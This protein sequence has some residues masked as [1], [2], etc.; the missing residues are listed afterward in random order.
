[1]ANGLNYNPA[2]MDS[3]FGIFDMWLRQF[4]A[5]NLAILQPVKITEIIDNGRLVNVQP[6]I[7]QF[8]TTGKEIA[9]TEII[10]N[11]PYMQPFGANGRFAFAPAV[12]DTGILIAC[13]WDITN[14]KKMGA[15]A[16]VASGRKFSWADGFFL[17]MGFNKQPDGATLENGS[18][19]VVSPNGV[20]ITTP[21]LTINGD[22]SITGNINANKTITASGEITGN[23]VKLS[24]HTHTVP[25]ASAITPPPAPTPQSGAPIPGT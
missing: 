14:Y 7:S 5:A 11:I 13:N 12:G 8:D 15:A 19:V 21:K 20:E 2:N 18:V 3:L 22:V 24:T 10:S 25:A 4:M 1:M 6:L 16:P 23:N 9:I 17:P